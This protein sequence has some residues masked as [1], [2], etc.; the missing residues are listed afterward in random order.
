MREA[1]G[2]PLQNISSELLN[3]VVSKEVQQNLKKY[4]MGVGKTPSKD[5]AN[6]RN[7]GTAEKAS[8][9][10][11]HYQNPVGMSPDRSALENYGDDYNSRQG[12]GQSK[13]IRE[14]IKE[15]DKGI[16]DKVNLMK[17]VIL[18]CGDAANSYKKIK[19]LVNKGDVNSIEK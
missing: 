10:K 7:F 6:N 17:M 16:G 5:K 19:T 12:L 1:L 9:S 18:K 15:L 13:E 4:K 11:R 8:P 3:R 2:Q 14:L